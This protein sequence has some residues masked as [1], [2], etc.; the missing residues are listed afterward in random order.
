MSFAALDRM[1]TRLVT[2][3][4][5]TLVDTDGKAH[6]YGAAGA[7]PAARVRIVDPAFPRKALLSANT[8]VGEAYMNGGIVLEEGRS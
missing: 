4:R 1:L 3:G 6:K 5:L 2:H 8:A 7:E